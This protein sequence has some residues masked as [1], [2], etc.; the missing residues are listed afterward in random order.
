[1]QRLGSALGADLVGD[2]LKIQGV[3]L[4]NAHHAPPGRHRDDN[5]VIVLVREVKVDLVHA[6]GMLEGMALAIGE[7]PDREQLAAA[8]ALRPTRYLQVVF[9][10]QL[11]LGVAPGGLVSQL[12][13]NP[14]WHAPLDLPLEVLAPGGVILVAFSEPPP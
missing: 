5:V 3:R 11:A 1:M 4:R 7:H 13:V 10:Y 6:P 12:H 9:G 14:G 8:R 2:A